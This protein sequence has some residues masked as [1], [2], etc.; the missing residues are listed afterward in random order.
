MNFEYKTIEDYSEL[1]HSV[2]NKVESNQLDLLDTIAELIVNKVEKNPMMGVYM[3]DY[4][5]AV[6]NE[7]FGRCGGL[8]MFKQIPYVQVFQRAGRLSNA[9]FDQGAPDPKTLNDGNYME[10]RYDGAYKDYYNLFSRKDLGYTDDDILF[11]GSF[12]GVAYEKLAIAQAFKDSGSNRT[13]IAITN[14]EFSDTL[15]SNVRGNIHLYDITDYT[16]ENYSGIGDCNI[17]IEGMPVKMCPTSSFSAMYSIW[18]LELMIA[19]RLVSK[20]KIP[21]VLQSVNLQN[22]HSGKENNEAT[23]NYTKNGY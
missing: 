22:D 2:L 17:Q 21:S 4:G 9:S 3:K 16:L 20:G 8:I 5:H 14:K 7:F 23:D 19:E 12:S 11:V 6:H 13:T 10:W 1:I 18:I 15:K